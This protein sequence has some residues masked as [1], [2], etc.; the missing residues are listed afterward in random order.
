MY[1]KYLFNA[2]F[3]ANFAANKSSFVIHPVQIYFP[4]KWLTTEYVQD[5]YLA[6]MSSVY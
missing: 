6:Q 2:A 3:S 5:R 1:F 4:Y